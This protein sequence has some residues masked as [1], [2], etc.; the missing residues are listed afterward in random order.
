MVGAFMR[1]DV[2]N[3]DHHL[4]K[5]SEYGALSQNKRTARSDRTGKLGENWTGGARADSRDG[6]LGLPQRQTLGTY[7]QNSRYSLSRS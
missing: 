6:Q 4:E 7:D 3:P 5:S 2:R 1:G